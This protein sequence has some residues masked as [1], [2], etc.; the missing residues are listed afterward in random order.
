MLIALAL[1]ALSALAVA[2]PALV[3]PPGR[4]VKAQD[5]IADVGFMRDLGG[6]YRFT[7]ISLSATEVFYEL[8]H[9]DREAGRMR[10]VPRAEAAAGDAVSTS[11]GIKRRR[12]EDAPRVDE[13]LDAAA[14]SVAAHDDGAFY[15]PIEAA[16]P[17]PRGDRQKLDVVDRLFH[18]DALG[19]VVATA[20]LGAAAILAAA[21]IALRRRRPELVSFDLKLTHVIPSCVQLVIFL[22]WGLYWRPLRYYA[23]FIVL[24]LVFAYLADAAVSL[25]TRR[26]LVIGFAPIPIVG[27]INLF[28]QFQPRSLYLSLA[29]ILLAFLSKALIRRKD[30]GAHV[31]NPSA[32]GVTV[33]G[34]VNLMFPSLGDGDN[35]LRF[36]LPP[37]MTELIFFLALVPQ[38][39]R[40]IVLVSMSAALA[41]GAY[42]RVTGLHFF[43]PMWAPVFLSLT[44]LG[45]DPVTIPRTGPGRVIFGALLGLGFVGLATALD[46]SGRS[47]FYAKVIP[48]PFVNLLT[49]WCDRIGARL[50]ARA[51]KWLAPE[52]NRAHVAAWVALV[53]IWMN[54]GVKIGGFSP[55]EHEAAGT[56][57]LVRRGDGAITCAEN[58]MFCRPFRIHDEIRGWIARR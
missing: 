1:M 38:M 58:P 7:A 34:I 16:L 12:L 53:V 45:T 27:S 50:G 32:F 3:I 52:H 35:A 47:D 51:G 15:V 18:P 8:S 43:V 9:G 10:L 46:F 29:A 28:V 33:V 37:N 25:A 44:L 42:H 57:L 30:T 22:Y 48:L 41:M 36:A 14:K 19:R 20:S 17:G 5:L 40:P 39:K 31:F 21:A 23:P 4:E 49:P 56:P 54:S 26:R 13:I 24:Q 55:K 11:F 6:G 2:G